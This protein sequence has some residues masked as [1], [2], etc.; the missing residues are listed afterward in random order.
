[1]VQD[2]TAERLLK[3]KQTQAER[4]AFWA[5]LAAGM[6]H[7]IRNPLVAIKTFAQLLPEQYDD[8][9]FRSQFSSIVSQEVN[10][11]SHIIDQIN[12]F[13][14]PPKLNIRPLD[15]REVVGRGVEWARRTKVGGGIPVEVDVETELPPVLGDAQALAE[16]VCHLV[17]NSLEAIDGQREPRIELLVRHQRNGEAKAAIAVS[18][19]D[20]GP[21]IPVALRDKVFSPF[22]TT[23]DR[24]MGL[25][26]AIVQR[27]V[28]DHNGREYI[29]TG[30]QGT[31]VTMVLPAASRSNGHET[32]PDRR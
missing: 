11:L 32:S 25:G 10:R 20:N 30:E 16:C 2:V 31:C 26:L 15:I 5:E 22:C 13:A 12:R 19:R 7:E 3:D 17:T 21:G 9:E 14:Y 29:E 18:V 27:V 28:I 4:A 8:P 23:K 1:L 6:S 24:G